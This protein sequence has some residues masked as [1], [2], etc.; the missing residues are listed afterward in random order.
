MLPLTVPWRQTAA[1]NK[2]K[3]AKA[4]VEPLNNGLS[5]NETMLFVVRHGQ[6]A[7]ESQ[8]NAIIL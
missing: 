6:R 5:D 2:A 4:K 7:D 3:K 8:G 1:G